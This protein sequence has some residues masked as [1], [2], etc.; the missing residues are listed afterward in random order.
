MTCCRPTAPLIMKALDE[1]NAQNAALDDETP[2][3]KAAL[4]ALDGRGRLE[5]EGLILK[6]RIHVRLKE[7]APARAAYAERWR[8]SRASPGVLNC[9]SI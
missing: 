7:I 5:G 3:L 2:Y 9:A 8:K 1:L 4:A 6:A